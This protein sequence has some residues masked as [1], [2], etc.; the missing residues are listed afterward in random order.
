MQSARLWYHR[1]SRGSFFIRSKNTYFRDVRVPSEQ[2]LMT[3][4]DVFLM[5]NS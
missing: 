2:K 4:E 1:S 5:L 3:R